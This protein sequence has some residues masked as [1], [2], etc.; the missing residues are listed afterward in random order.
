MNCSVCGLLLQ[1]LPD[2]ES[3]FRYWV[4]PVESVSGLVSA[5]KHSDPNNP[6]P[7]QRVRDKRIGV[8][9]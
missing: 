6:K 3:G 7:Y 2:S 9:P 8:R 4:C 5:F 1:S